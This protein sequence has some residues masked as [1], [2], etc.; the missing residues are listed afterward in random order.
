MIHNI[1]HYKIN[2]ESLEL[3]LAAIPTFV[4]AI[5]ANEPETFYE[6]YQHYDEPARFVH[7]MSF[8]N[9]DAEKTHQAAEYT[10]A[11]VAALYPNCIEMPAFT[12]LNLLATT[13][14]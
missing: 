7:T 6:A 3:V 14:R 11:F 4:A 9:A 1:V 8:P 10:N 2:I 13:G 12:G 5:H